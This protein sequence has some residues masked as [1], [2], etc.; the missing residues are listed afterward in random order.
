VVFTEG[1]AQSKNPD[2]L[3]FV[4]QQ[5]AAAMSQLT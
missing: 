4:S 5:V 1:K 2:I 3:P